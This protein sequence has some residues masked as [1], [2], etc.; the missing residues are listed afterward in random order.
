MKEGNVTYIHHIAVD[1]ESFPRL[2]H[3]L[4]TYEQEHPNSIKTHGVGFL[5][6]AYLVYANVDLREPLKARRFDSWTS[7]L[8]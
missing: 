6:K 2:K 8:K 4:E 3:F 1:A 7:F 5:G